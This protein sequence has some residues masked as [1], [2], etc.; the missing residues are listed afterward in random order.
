M[1]SR[2]HKRPSRSCSKENMKDPY[3]DPRIEYI[4]RSDELHDPNGCLLL[5]HPPEKG[6]EYIIGAD[7][8]G[9]LGLSNSVAHVLKV[10]TADTPDRQEAEYACNFLSTTEFAQVLNTLGHLYWNWDMDLP[11]VLNV[12]NNN[13]GHSVLGTLV[14]QLNYMNLFQDVASYK[15]NRPANVQWGTGV[16]DK[17]RTQLVMLGESRLKYGQ[18]EIWSPFFL[19][20]MS[21]FQI[22][23]IKHVDALSREI[24]A[25]AGKFEGKVKDD[26]LFAGFHAIWAGNQLNPDLLIEREKKRIKTVK[27]AQLPEEEKPDWRNSPISYDKMMEEMEWI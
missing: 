1:V 17:V 6:P 5:F 12:E 2:R 18:W 14:E 13:Y 19:E 15:V 8:G 10:G 26:R 23:N 7:V 22:T 24:M 16:F 11:A 25:S 3:L 20:E 27:L 21:D 9:G 4:G